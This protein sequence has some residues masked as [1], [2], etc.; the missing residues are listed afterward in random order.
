MKLSERIRGPL[1]ST[2]IRIPEMKEQWV[3]PQSE[4]SDGLSG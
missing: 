2:L 4:P 1:G 3:V